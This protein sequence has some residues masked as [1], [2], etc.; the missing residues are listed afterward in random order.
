MK[1][2]TLVIA[3]VLLST[4]VSAKPGPTIIVA[5]QG[6]SI[7]LTEVNIAYLN[8]TTPTVRKTISNFSTGGTIRNNDV[9]D[10]IISLLKN[11]K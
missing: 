4:I 11:K 6:K 8:T 7:K 1:K 2:N 10:L 3:L 5:S 9:A